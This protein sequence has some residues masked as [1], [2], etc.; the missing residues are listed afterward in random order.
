MGLRH[1]VVVDG[2]LFVVGMI[3]R[4]DMNEHR[5]AHYWQEE[6]SRGGCVVM[7]LSDER[8]VC[9]ASRCRKR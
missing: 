6:V 5:L 2:D 7:C 9:R 4:T 8:C 1:I 3:T